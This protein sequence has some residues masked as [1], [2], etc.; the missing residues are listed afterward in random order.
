MT[1]EAKRKIMKMETYAKFPYL[2]EVTYKKNDGTQ[3]VLRFANSDEDIEYDDE[4]F[5][6]GYF[7]I[8]PPTRENGEISDA[9]ITIS[10]IDQTWIERIRNTSKRSTIRFIAVIQHEENGETV[11]EPIEDMEFELTKAT[12]DDSAIQ[13]T[14]EFDNLLDINLPLDEMT[15]LNC[16]QLG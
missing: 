16:P 4:T 3:E 8:T 10:A 13:W 2:I 12:W 11:I 15:S 14:M 9:K 7:E 5:T 6:A 1:T